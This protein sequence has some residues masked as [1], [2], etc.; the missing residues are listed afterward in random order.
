MIAFVRRVLR[1]SVLAFKHRGR[2]VGISFRSFVSRNAVF[3][4]MNVV[5]RG[6]RFYGC[7][8]YGSYVGN[9]CHF[10]GAIGRF[11]SIASNVTVV[12]GAHPTSSFVSTHPAFFSLCMPSGDTF[13]TEQKFAEQ[14]YARRD[15]PVVIGND[16]WIGEGVMILSGV[17]IHDGA[18]VA[19]GSVVTRDVDSYAIVGGVPAKLIRWRFSEEQIT[20]LLATAWWERPLD[21]IRENADIFEDVNTFLVAVDPDS[22]KNGSAER[23]PRIC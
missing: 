19:A 2:N 9:D 3:E 8:G 15:C 18:I 22:T 17:T 14:V 16:V 4:G 20:S 1:H 12:S 11:C 6:T 21:W 5:G 13:V 7:M 23:D 10:G